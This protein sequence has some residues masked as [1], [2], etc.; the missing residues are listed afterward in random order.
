[1][2]IC[3]IAPGF[4]P[5][6]SNKANAPNSI[7]KNLSERL[8]CLGND[9]DVISHI[10]DNAKECQAFNIIGL[11]ENP[12]AKRIVPVRDVIYSIA[13][14]RKLSELIRTNDYDIVHFHSPL[15]ALFGSMVARNRSICTVY[16]N[17]NP[18]IGSSRN[19]KKFN[20]IS[21][22]RQ[23]NASGLPIVI[24]IGSL[25]AESLAF[26]AVDRIVAVSNQLRNNI[27]NYFNVEP[28]KVKWIPNGVNTE[29]FNPNVESFRLREK[30]N[31]IGKRV[32][33]NLARI[34][35]YKN[36]MNLIKS[37]PEI[38]KLDREAVFLFVGPISPPFLSYYES[39]NKFVDRNNL[40]KYVI[41]TNSVDE[42]L[43]PL[44]YSIADIFILPSI[45]EGGSPLVLLQAMSSGKAI[46]ASSIPQNL[47]V[48]INGNEMLFV[49]PLNENDIST[50]IRL[51]LDDNTL[52]SRLEVYSRGTALRHFDWGV[53]A[54][55]TVSLYDQFNRKVI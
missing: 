39:I 24:N 51:I 47:E 17:G 2:R 25:Y 1:M 20:K 37:I 28:N 48:A 14:A 32:I 7:I 45:S 41:F 13:S 42:K 10:S 9:V 52:K 22:A 26:K 54:R 5:L 33:L 23:L 16:T 30:L 15:T 31:L 27:I 3:Q 21:L 44:F 4:T 35:P 50:A 46:I 11:D 12:F 19:I 40:N 6:I 38:I 55:Q 34:A 43:L 29:I 36:Q 53:V 49:D 8:I 18:N